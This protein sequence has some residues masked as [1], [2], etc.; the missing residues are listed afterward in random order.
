MARGD[1]V[2]EVG[3]HTSSG[4]THSVQPSSG[5]EWVIR[6]FGGNGDDSI[7]FEYY[8]GST[9]SIIQR[10]VDA[11]VTG[12]MMTCPVTYTHYAR[13]RSTASGNRN[14][15]YSGYITKD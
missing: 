9:E 10:G 1:V 5:V 4:A 15:A 11:E 2:I 6:C 13:T 3:R 7:V 14:W 12:G 8:D